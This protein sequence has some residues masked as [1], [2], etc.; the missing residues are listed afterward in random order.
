MTVPP[1]E[2]L[3]QQQRWEQLH[4][5]SLTMDEDTAGA[6]HTPPQPAA[7]PTG[8]PKSQTSQ[9]EAEKAEELEDEAEWEE[10]SGQVPTRLAA[11]AARQ[12]LQTVLQDVK[13]ASQL[14][15]QVPDS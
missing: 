14:V 7:Q 11:L 13:Q 9:P 1:E 8:P 10:G 4:T 5:P 3:L 12:L 15:N 2:V 6:G